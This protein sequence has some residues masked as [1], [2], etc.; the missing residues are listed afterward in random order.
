MLLYDSNGKFEP[1]FHIQSKATLE[2]KGIIRLNNDI[3]MS[4]KNLIFL[5]N[6]LKNQPININL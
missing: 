3:N 5:K 6:H 1:I 2:P 4:S